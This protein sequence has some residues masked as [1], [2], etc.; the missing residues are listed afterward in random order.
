MR[1]FHWCP[2]DKRITGKGCFDSH[3]EL[4]V[5]TLPQQTVHRETY[6][7][8][9]MTLV[10][11]FRGMDITHYHVLPLGSSICLLPSI[12]LSTGMECRQTTPFE[13]P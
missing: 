13:L 3:V 8:Q 9:R 10:I 2:S 5:G 7:E 1:L 4:F 6:N 11:L 12:P